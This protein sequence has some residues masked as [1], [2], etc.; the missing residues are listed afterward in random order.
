MKMCN[1]CKGT[2]KVTTIF[3]GDHQGSTEMKYLTEICECQDPLNPDD[4]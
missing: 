2:G 1:E 4:L 3:Y